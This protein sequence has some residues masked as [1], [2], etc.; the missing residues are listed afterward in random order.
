LGGYT[1]ERIRTLQPDL[2]RRK[3]SLNIGYHSGKFVSVPFRDVGKGESNYKLVKDIVNHEGN[4]RYIIQGYSEPGS[5]MIGNIIWPVDR[6][7]IRNNK[8]NIG[9]SSKILEQ[10]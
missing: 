7:R 3:W 9:V 6:K 2:K 4:G 10:G 5:M 8:N 1:D